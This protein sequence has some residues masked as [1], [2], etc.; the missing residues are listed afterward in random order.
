[1]SLHSGCSP[2]GMHPEWSQAAPRRE[3]RDRC[4][5]SSR[6]S[7]SPGRAGSDALFWPES[8][9]PDERRH[10]FLTPAIQLLAVEEKG[11][12]RD[13]K[14]DRLGRWPD[15]A[16]GR[17]RA[18]AALQRLARIERNAEVDFLPNRDR[19]VR[20]RRHRP[21]LRHGVG[22]KRLVAGEAIGERFGQGPIR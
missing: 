5:K 11:H 13:A 22:Q 15:P 8:C 3:C 4:P 10:A 16:L 18:N 14:T 19:A 12:T 17:S 20:Q 2:E 9:A 1:R 21:I 6:K 7:R